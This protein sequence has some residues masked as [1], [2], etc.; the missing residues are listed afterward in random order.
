MVLRLLLLESLLPS[1][2][3]FMLRKGSIVS[4][5]AVCTI[6]LYRITVLVCCY[7]LTRLSLIGTC[8][9]LHG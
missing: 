9:W 4:S 7:K 8:N 6:L 1:A 2:R 3:L 5:N